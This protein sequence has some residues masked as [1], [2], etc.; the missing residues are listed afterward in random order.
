MESVPTIFSLNTVEAMQKH[1]KESVPQDSLL[2]DAAVIMH[3]A[4]RW[5]CIINSLLN[6]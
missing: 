6:R 4:S 3:I 1:K 5:H 2:M